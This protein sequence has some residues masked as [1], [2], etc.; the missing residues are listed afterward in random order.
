METNWVAEGNGL[1][2]ERGGSFD[3]GAL[4]R[5]LSSFVDEGSPE[6]HRYYLS[7][8]TVL[9]MLRDRG[10]SVPSSEIDLSLQEFRVIHGQNPDIDRLKFSATHKSDPSKRILVIF[11][12]TGVLKVSSVRLIAAQIVNRDSLTGLILILQNQITNQ[13][14]KAVDLFS[15]KVE[16]FQITD[17][18]V[19]ITKHLL[20]PKHE[21]LTDREKEK[22]LKKYSIEEKQLPRLLKKDAI[23]HYYGLEKGQVVKVTHTG[24][25]TESHVTYRCVW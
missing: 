13:A 23:A 24:D 1:G 22:L 16:M 3:M 25:I 9:E 12:G 19:N 4:G 17:L 6:S 10:Y 18:L 2:A 5:C 21:V 8:R 7:R 15:F 11:C 14:L 20:K